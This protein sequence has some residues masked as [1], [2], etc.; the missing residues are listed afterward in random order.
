[1]LG[2]QF[3]ILFMEYIGRKYN[4]FKGVGCGVIICL[5]CF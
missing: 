4:V 5:I 3:E 1:M 2:G